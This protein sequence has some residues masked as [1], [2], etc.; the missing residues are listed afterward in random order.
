MDLHTA[1]ITNGVE[2]TQQ[3]PPLHL[4]VMENVD[5]ISPEEGTARDGIKLSIYGLYTTKRQGVPFDQL[6]YTSN[7]PITLVEPL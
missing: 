2:V 7:L 5:E 4:L 1:K 6:S 3:L